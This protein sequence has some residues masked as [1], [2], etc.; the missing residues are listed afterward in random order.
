MHYVVQWH[1]SMFGSRIMEACVAQGTG[2]PG[3]PKVC[4]GYVSYSLWKYR[5]NRLPRGDARDTLTESED[6]P[7]LGRPK[8]LIRTRDAAPHV[9]GEFTPMDSDS[10]WHS[11][12]GSQI[13]GPNLRSPLEK[14]LH[15]DPWSVPTR[16]PRSLGRPF[17]NRG[18]EH[19]GEAPGAKF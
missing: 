6:W 2:R 13:G 3:D 19:V 8:I 12:P 1:R 16:F 15:H 9:S 5:P 11:R 4:P 10:L 18:V 14:V 7:I 17:G